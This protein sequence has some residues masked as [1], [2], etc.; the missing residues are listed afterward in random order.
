[1]RNGLV[2]VLLTGIIGTPLLAA[3]EM[4][5]QPVYVGVRACSRCHQGKDMGQQDSLWMMSKHAR[6][7][8]SLA[9]PEAKLIAE[10]S[11]IPQAPKESPL[12]LGC[13]ATGAHVEEWERDDEFR[14]E[15]GV[16]C[17]KCHGPGSVRPG[18]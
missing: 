9:K 5:K 6:A 13:H 4:K 3:Y 1:M 16:Q 2:C 17:E 8:A 7:Y 15:D 11:G 14:I 12:C 10:L 18:S